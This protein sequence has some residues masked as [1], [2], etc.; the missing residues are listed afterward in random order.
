MTTPTIIQGFSW[1]MAGP[2][3]FAS[4]AAW[5]FWRNIVPRQLRGLQVA[6]QTG[7]KKYEVHR[8]TDSVEDVRKLLTREG[9]RLGVVSYLMALTGSLVLLFE[10]IN[11]RTGVTVGYHAPSVAFA[12]VLIAVPAVVSS[13][14]SLGAQVIKPHGVSRASLQS[15]SNLRNASYFALTMAWMLLAFGVGMVLEA[16]A[17]SPTMRYSTM[18][19]VA[20]S[21][22]VLAYGRI[23][24]SSWHAL[25]QSSSQIAKGGASPFHNHLPNA[26]QQFIAQVVHFN[27]I[28]MP[29]V[30]F[31][32]LVSLILLIYNPDLFVHSDRVV[33]LPEYRVQSTYM[34]EGGVLGFALIELFS[35]IPQAGIRVPIVTTLLLFLL[36][37]VAAIGFL[38]VYE[39][40][41]ILFLDIQDVSG[42]GGIR[43]ADSRLLRAEP[44]QQANV[45]NFCFTGF[46]GQSMLLLALAMITFWD[47]SFLPQGTGCGSWEGNVCNVLE[48]DMLEQLTWML[49]AGGQVAFLLVWALSRKRS[50]TL[51]EIT[52]DASM[53]EDR[54]RL[55]G[56]S[57]MIYLKQRST[58]VL[59]GN[60]DWTT[61]IERYESSTQGREAMLVGL[62]MIRST[63]AKMLLYTGLGRWDDAEEL[64]VDL[65]ALQGGRDAQISRLV[66]CAASLA[67]RDYREAVP[68]L[69]LLDNSD[70]EAVRLRWV[71]SVLTGQHHLDKEAKSMLSVDPLRKDNIRMLEQFDGEGTVLRKTPIKQ[72]SQR[73]MYLSEIARMRLT[74]QSEEA[75]NHLERQLAALDEGAWPH[76]QLVAALLNLDD[77]RT[78]TAVSAI[79]KLSKQHPRHPH[80]RAV[81]H[82]LAGMGQAKRPASEPTRIQWLLEGETDWKQAWGQHNVAPPPTLE[83]TS[84]REHAMNANA[85]MLLLSEEGTN[86]RAAKKAMKS[87][88]DEVPVGLFTHLTGLTITIGG[89]PVDLG[90]PANINLNA[91]R[92]HGL[93][94]R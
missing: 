56:M 93:L 17:F 54:T 4:L 34:E 23:L 22:A 57:D 19:L 89:M 25:K 84:L 87:L 20:F 40:A 63:K 65:L 74:G 30:A 59:L 5:F 27:L 92:K 66:L 73:S 86:Q 7:E 42:R 64:A 50:T 33:N 11:F 71:A 8:V 21:P 32:T 16:A 75:L 82:Q 14:T 90:L 3:L 70:I 41:R 62:D 53:D 39:V 55:R 91:A 28:V 12:L 47:S 80:I 58:S 60:D 45:L 31:N 88:V 29:F 37:N 10:F 67:Q 15:N 2:L 6:F 46:A 49:A 85:W 38:F 48:K 52:F 77:G 9:T 1:N 68:R 36:L 72:P 83:N 43:L 69:A 44:I 79:K 51:S 94:D 35:F 18:A 13:G 78:L 24:G 61:A 81:M 76:G 26:R